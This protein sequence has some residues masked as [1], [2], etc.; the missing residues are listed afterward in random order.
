[1]RIYVGLKDYFSGSPDLDSFRATSG[2]PVLQ[3]VHSVDVAECASLKGTYIFREKVKIAAQDQNYI[4][5]FKH[6]DP[7]NWFQLTFKKA[8]DTTIATTEPLVSEVVGTVIDTIRADIGD[9]DLQDPAFSDEEYMQKI[10]FAMRRYKGE[11]NLSFIEEEDYP[12]IALLTRIDIANIIAYDHAKY[13]ALQAP[14][15]Q[16]DKSQVMNHYLQVAQGLEEYWAKIKRDLGLGSG[17]RNSDSIIT[18]LPS[19]NV[20]TAT[21]MSFRAGRIISNTDPRKI[22][23]RFT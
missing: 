1:V 19:P 10:R 11:K 3:D 23:N 8:D 12:V 5:V 9:T 14:E 13:F 17:G 21:R 4:E 20:V 15:A 16:L 7:A 6:H 18:E 22:L 2:R